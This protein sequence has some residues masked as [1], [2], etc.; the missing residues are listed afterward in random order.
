MQAELEQHLVDEDEPNRKN[1]IARKTIKFTAGAFE[2][3]T[4]RDRAGTFESQLIKK[5]QTHLT[6]DLE[7]RAIGLFALG[8]R[9]QDIRGHIE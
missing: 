2:L 3:E 5:H 7:R 9:Y 6:D 4:S 1:G 8:N